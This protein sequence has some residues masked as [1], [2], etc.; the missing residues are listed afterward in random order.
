MLSELGVTTCTAAPST[1]ENTTAFS[2]FVPS[3]ATSPSL[4]EALKPGAIVV[5]D[6][7]LICKGSGSA[8]LISDLREKV[9]NI[10]SGA[11]ASGGEVV[12]VT[13]VP[14]AVHE[15]FEYSQLELFRGKADSL[16]LSRT[17]RLDSLSAHGYGPPPEI[18]A[19]TEQIMQD[20][21]AATGISVTDPTTLKARLFSTTGNG[22]VP[23]RPSRKL[24][25]ASIYGKICGPC[26]DDCDDSNNG[27]CDDGGEGSAHY[28]CHLGVCTHMRPQSLARSSPAS[29]AVCMTGA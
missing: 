12:V 17:A 11:E 19:S 6:D 22:S 26:N 3:G 10:S 25:D 5:G 13:T 2:L 16:H 29:P 9:L 1:V 23:L 4:R 27:V 28:T 18:F 7:D 24:G 21:K 15:C 14:A 20:A 8:P